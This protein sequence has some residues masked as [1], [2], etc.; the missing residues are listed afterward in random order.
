MA[1]TSLNHILI[2]CP[3][4][5]LLFYYDSIDSCKCVNC[6]RHF[7][8]TFPLNDDTSKGRKNSKKKSAIYLRELVS[9]HVADPPGFVFCSLAESWHHQGLEVLLR[10]QSGNADT[11][12][13]SKQ[14]H[15]VLMEEGHVINLDISGFV[16]QEKMQIW[17]QRQ[18][19]LRKKRRQ[20]H[21]P[22]HQRPTPWRGKWCHFLHNPARGL[23][24]IPPV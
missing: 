4:N 15:R 3:L 6:L 17:V 2:C 11:S 23:W 20:Q 5:R 14:P 18:F 1:I 19:K 16:S 9:H 10:Q 13:H 7:L 21:I 8:V 12:L 24:Q 22:A